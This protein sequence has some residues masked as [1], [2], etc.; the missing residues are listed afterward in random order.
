MA[1]HGVNNCQ[2]TSGGVVV[3]EHT[4]RHY[5][6]GSDRAHG[7]SALSKLIIRDCQLSYHPIVDVV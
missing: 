5:L 7:I 1:C 6:C 4:I 3:C 2:S